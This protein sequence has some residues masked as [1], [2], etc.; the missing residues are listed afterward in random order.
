MATEMHWYSGSAWHKA[1][2]M[3]VWDSSQWKEAI[4]MYIWDDGTT[5][6]RLC[7]QSPNACFAY[8]GEP[9]TSITDCAVFQ[10]TQYHSNSTDPYADYLS[11]DVFIYDSNGCASGVGSGFFQLNVNGFDYNFETN[12]AS[13]IIDAFVV[14]C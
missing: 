3:H 7:H 13:K 4:R 10:S 2:E 5:T 14:N 9:V 6:W 11:F 12:G 1:L 8:T